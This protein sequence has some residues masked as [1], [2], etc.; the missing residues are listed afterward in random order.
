[1][2]NGEPLIVR[3]AMKP[4]PTL[5]KP[6]AL[7][8]H[9]DARARAGAARAHRLLHRAGR[10]RGRRG[11][12]RARARRR[13][14]AE[15]R[16]RSHRRR[17]RQARC[18]PTSETDRVALVLIGF[19][20]AGKSTLAV[21]TGRAARARADRRRR[22]AG[23]ALRALGRP[24]VRASRRAGVS[25]GGGGARVRAA[26]ERRRPRCDRA[27]RRQ[28]PLRTGARRRWQRHTTALLDVE[29]DV[30]WERVH[31][32]RH[33]AERPL[34]RDREAFVA[35]HAER[36]GMY[37]AARR[38]PAPVGRVGLRRVPGAGRARPAA[39]RRPGSAS[40]IW[41]FERSRSRAFCVSDETV[42]GS[43]R[44]ATGRGWRRPSRFPPGES[45]QDARER[46][47]RVDASSWRAGM[48]RA[49][50]VVALGGGVVGDLAGFCAA[51]YQR[52][53]PVVQVPTTLV[54]QVDSAYGGKTGVDLPAGEEL[55]R[56]LP[57]ARG[58]A[59][60]PR[61]CSRRCPRRSSPRAGSRC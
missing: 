17:A 52:G 14:P 13:L 36:R 47:A 25:R 45:T 58:R 27:R 46:R 59:R 40:A 30:A 38:R 16:R 37:E 56:R 54:A 8:R 23:G 10:R 19:M 44:G 31:V 41:P 32:L 33:A 39:R 53:V 5:T 22:A 34:A 24:R 7:G 60:R 4:L 28:R 2:T 43:V 21:R 26:G 51:T 15:V 12:G 9:R 49:D 29:P 50:H 48:T 42:C 35:L 20:G 18:A 1:M 6:L 57:P 55:R 11:D 61:P 3:G